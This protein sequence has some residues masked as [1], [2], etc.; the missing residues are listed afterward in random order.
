M[1]GMMNSDQAIKLAY[2]FGETHEK[3]LVKL[4]EIKTRAVDDGISDAAFD[5]ALHDWYGAQIVSD[6]K[7]YRS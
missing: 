3:L 7:E 4:D 6:L 5:L 2:A 1:G